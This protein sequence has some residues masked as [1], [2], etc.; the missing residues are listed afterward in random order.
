MKV[1]RQTV[2]ELLTKDETGNGNTKISSRLVRLD[3]G[4]PHTKNEVSISNGSKVM[5]K[6]PKPEVEMQNC[7][8]SISVANSGPTYQI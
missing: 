8:F 4:C 7:I 6:S 5:I 3:I 2:H 1:L